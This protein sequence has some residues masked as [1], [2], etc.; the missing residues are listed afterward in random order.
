MSLTREIVSIRSRLQQLRREWQDAVFKND[1]EMPE[2]K[3]LSYEIQLLQNHLNALEVE[4]NE[5]KV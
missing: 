4:R 5:R 1:L 3:E 2:V